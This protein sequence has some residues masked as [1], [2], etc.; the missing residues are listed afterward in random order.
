MHYEECRPKSLPKCQGPLGWMTSTLPVHREAVAVVKE[1]RHQVSRQLHYSVDPLG[2][3]GEIRVLYIQNPKTTLA[4]RRAWSLPI[5]KSYPSSIPLLGSSPKE[6]AHTHSK[7]ILNGSR[8]PQDGKE[9]GGAGGEDCLDQDQMAHVFHPS[10]CRFTFSII[11]CQSYIK[12]RAAD[13]GI[14]RYL[15]GRDSRGVARIAGHR[16]VSSSGIPKVTSVDLS[17]S[18]QRPEVPNVLCRLCGSL[19]QIHRVVGVLE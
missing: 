10:S 6:S 14:P 13:S 16:T 12:T 15:M 1:L 5:H 11:D 19:E 7:P 3:E 9:K 8:G 2:E 17:R 4:E 18:R